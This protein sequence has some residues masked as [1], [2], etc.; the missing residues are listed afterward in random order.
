MGFLKYIFKSD[1]DLE[2]EYE[3]ERQK[4]LKNGSRKHSK[5]MASL[6]R[7]MCRRS[8][9]KYEKEHRKSKDSNFRWTDANRWDKD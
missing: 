7:E 8:D 6:N 1:S 4:W 5:K 3:K 9:I 2:N